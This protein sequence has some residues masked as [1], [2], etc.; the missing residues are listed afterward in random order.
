MYDP[1]SVFVLCAPFFCLAVQDFLSRWNHI[2]PFRTNSARAYL[3]VIRQRIF[4]IC[5]Q[6]GQCCSWHRVDSM[7]M[8]MFCC[9]TAVF[10]S[11]SP[12]FGILSQAPSTA[13]WPE[14]TESSC[15][16]DWR[17]EARRLWCV[18]TSIP[19]QLTIGANSFII[20]KQLHVLEKQ[21]LLKFGMKFKHCLNI[22]VM[23]SSSLTM[24]RVIYFIIKFTLLMNNKFFYASCVLYTVYLAGLARAKSFPTK[25]YSHEV[26]T[27]W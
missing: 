23:F 15:E 18:S 20:C 3:S 25:T 9:L 26:V 2:L 21:Q 11:N 4:Y 19:L 22:A 12:W 27:L 7:W 1:V 16:P 5:Q 24:Q 14:A 8:W 10:V 17:I 6:S 13:S